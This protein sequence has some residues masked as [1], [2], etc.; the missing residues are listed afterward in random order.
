MTQPINLLTKHNILHYEIIGECWVFRGYIGHKGYGQVSW[1]GHTHNAHRVMYALEVGPI[2]EGMLVCHTC[3]NRPCINPAHLFLGTDR[4]N[5][6]DMVSKGRNVVP[7]GTANG[8]ATITECEVLKIREMLNRGL[9]PAAVARTMKISK[10]I[11]CGIHRG[12]NWKH[13]RANQ[14]T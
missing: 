11:V 3:D 8:H 13:V 2:P 7:L 1:Q 5:Y 6:N 4:D 14:S 10:H 9:P 12:K